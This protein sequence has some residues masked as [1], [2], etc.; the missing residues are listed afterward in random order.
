MSACPHKALI[1]HRRETRV[2]VRNYTCNKLTVPSG[3]LPIPARHCG[4][5]YV[6]PKFGCTQYGQDAGSDTMCVVVGSARLI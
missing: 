2:N 3:P 1:G 5:V 4:G 6:T